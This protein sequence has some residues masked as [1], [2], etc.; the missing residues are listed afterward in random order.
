V[1]VR[2]KIRLRVTRFVS[3]VS[4]ICLRVTRVGI[5]VPLCALVSLRVMR[6][7]CHA[8]RVS[9]VSGWVAA[10]FVSVS[11]SCVFAVRVCFLCVLDKSPGVNKPPR[12]PP[13]SP[14]EGGEHYLHFEE[15][16]GARRAQFFRSELM[17]IGFQWK[18]RFSRRQPRNRGEGEGQGWRGLINFGPKSVASLWG[19]GGF[20]NRRSLVCA[21]RG[22]PRQS[23]RTP[24]TRFWHQGP[25]SSKIKLGPGGL[26]KSSAS[27]G[28]P[29]CWGGSL[30]G[31]QGGAQS[32]LDNHFPSPV[33]CNTRP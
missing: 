6:V 33:L 22:F 18:R 10:W 5:R 28:V 25:P 21:R 2:V 8:C 23:A 30:V 9:R 4:D 15:I 13:G 24:E 16:V 17:H 29:L 26:P 1:P 3:R 20:I 11:G 14:E 27:L 7:A 32:V 12:G 31:L 19:R